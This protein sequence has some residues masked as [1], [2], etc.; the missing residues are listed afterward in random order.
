MK[1]I[2][3]KTNGTIEIDLEKVVRE[4]WAAILCRS[5]LVIDELDGWDEY[6]HWEEGQMRIVKKKSDGELRNGEQI[7]L[8]F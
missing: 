6:D 7:E 3:M 1:V 2:E 4:E 5:E 8:T